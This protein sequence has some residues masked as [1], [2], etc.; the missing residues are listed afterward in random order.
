MSGLDKYS[1]ALMAR[2]LDQIVNETKKGLA[3]YKERKKNDFK[4]SDGG[5]RSEPGLGGYEG[6]KALVAS[7][8]GNR[9]QSTNVQRSRPEIA[10][11]GEEH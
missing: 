9:G 7:N 1:G 5:K 3:A 11:G 2:F 6:R 10:K 8:G 4:I